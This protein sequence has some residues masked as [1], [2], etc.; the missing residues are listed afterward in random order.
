M[1][2]LACGRQ[3][4][5]L[6]DAI[7]TSRNMLGD[8]TVVWDWKGKL[9]C[10]NLQVSKIE[11]YL[12]S[13]MYLWS[14]GMF[15]HGSCFQIFDILL[16]SPKLNYLLQP[17]NYWYCILSNRNEFPIRAFSLEVMYMYTDCLILKWTKYEKNVVS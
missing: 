16:K 4:L 1:I 7:E 11:E 3:M 15:N 2:R 17:S 5:M 14:L 10:F 8:I 12:S 13:S 6:R 9:T